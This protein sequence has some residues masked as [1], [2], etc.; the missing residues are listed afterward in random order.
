VLSTE[1]RTLKISQFED[2]SLNI[3]ESREANLDQFQMQNPFESS[4]RHARFGSGLPSGSN[5]VRSSFADDVQD[6]ITCDFHQPCLERTCDPAA[7]QSAQ[8]FFDHTGSG[9]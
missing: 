4:I 5:R 8:H 9:I 1:S 6:M 2:R 3:C 7:R